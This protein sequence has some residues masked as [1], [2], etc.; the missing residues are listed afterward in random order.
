[1]QALFTLLKPTARCGRGGMVAAGRLGQNNTIT[2]SSPVQIGSLTTWLKASAGYAHALAL[3]TDGS[4]WAW[5]NNAWGNLG[6]NN[7]V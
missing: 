6:D 5:G 3:K 1:M 4:L 2:Y 7:T